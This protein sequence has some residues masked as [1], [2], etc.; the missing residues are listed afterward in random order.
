MTP[1]VI[2][3][4]RDLVEQGAT[5][6]GPKPKFSPTLRDYPESEAEVSRIANQLWGNGNERE[7]RLGKGRV[8]S[9]QKIPDVI[10]HLHLA[11]DF[12]FTGR[13]SDADIV[14]LHRHAG[15]T[16]I[17]FVANRQR[18][19]EE[20]LCSFRVNGKEPELWFPET[21]KLKRPVIYDFAE[22]RTHLP[23]QL[24]PAESVFVVFLLSPEG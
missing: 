12:E 9:N 3:K 23:I 17:Y 1:P 7:R 13:N 24:G 14:W 15:E 4:L 10:E 8:F 21:G 6:V 11:P 18:R 19:P 20:I 5:L 2:R 22:G 16:E